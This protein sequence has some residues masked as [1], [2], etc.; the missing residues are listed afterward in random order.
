MIGRC[1]FTYREVSQPT[2][3][4]LAV[5]CEL[6]ATHRVRYR[7]LGQEASVVHCL[8]H[9]SLVAH[10]RGGSIESID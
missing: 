2:D 5:P 3:G 10:C 6:P 9:A 1:A 8:A 7:L 4:L